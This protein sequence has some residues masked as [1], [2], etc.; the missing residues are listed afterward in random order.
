MLED[1]DIKSVKIYIDNIQ[2]SRL[3]II[4]ICHDLDF[5]VHSPNDIYTPRKHLT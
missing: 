4:D 5:T 2:L 1:V 3:D